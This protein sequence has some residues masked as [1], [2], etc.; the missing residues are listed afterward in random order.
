[1]Q[2]PAIEGDI[3]D[4]GKVRLHPYPIHFIKFEIDASCTSIIVSIDKY[5]RIVMEMN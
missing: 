2:G 3:I 1:M 4:E 5:L